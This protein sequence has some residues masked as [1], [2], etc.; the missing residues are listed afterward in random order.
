MSF[1]TH[2]GFPPQREFGLVQCATPN[3]VLACGCLEG[4]FEVVN[5]A[6]TKLS[7]SLQHC[8]YSSSSSS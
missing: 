1:K 8:F 7:I 6:I 5:I 2:F 3:Q 4:L